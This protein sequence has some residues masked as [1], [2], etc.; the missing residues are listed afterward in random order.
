MLMT[1]STS[2]SSIA[3][4]S[5]AIKVSIENG[6]VLR[7]DGSESHKVVNVTINLLRIV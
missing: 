1:F 7:S 4:Q 3:P 5:D 2:Y 6:G